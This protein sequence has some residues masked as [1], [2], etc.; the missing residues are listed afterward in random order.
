MIKDVCVLVGGSGGTLASQVSRLGRRE[1]VCL[2]CVGFGLIT[3]SMVQV[4]EDRANVP[5]Y[6]SYVSNIRARAARD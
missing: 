3:T 4:A 6:A 1:A 2:R 5:L